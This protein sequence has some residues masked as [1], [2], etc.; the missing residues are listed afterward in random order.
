MELS[1]PAD[2][3]SHGAIVLPDSTDSYPEARTRPGA[4]IAEHLGGVDRDGSGVPSPS[5]S[6]F[7]IRPTIDSN[8]DRSTQYIPPLAPSKPHVHAAS[9]WP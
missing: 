7:R 9:A 4:D 3:L 8:V 1:N 5:G 2:A 6:P